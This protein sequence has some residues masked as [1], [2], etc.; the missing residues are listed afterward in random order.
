MSIR[1]TNVD[2]I[3]EAR[4]SSLPTIGR[5]KPLNARGFEGDLTFRRTPDGLK[6]YIKA[7]HQW[8]G[9]KVGESFDGLEK[10]IKEVK[11]KVDTIKQ[12][13][14]PSTYSVTGDF[15]LDA[16]GDISLDAD[17]GEI[18]IKD[19]GTTFGTFTTDSSRTSL[20]LYENAGASADDY[21]S[22]LVQT[23]GATVISTVDAAGQSG[24]IIISPDGELEL[25]A[26][27][28]EAVIVDANTTA[29]ASGTNEGLQIDYDHTGI[30]ASG[31]TVT[32]VALDIDLNSNAPTH[33]GTVVNYGI[34]IELTAATSGV[35]NQT[36]IY[37]KVLS[38]DSNTGYTSR[39]T[40]GGMDFQLLSTANTSDYCS[41]STTTNGAT[42]I[43]TVDADAANADLTVNIDGDI[44]LNSVTGV[45]IA[46]NNSTEFSVAK[47][48]YAG[49]ILGYQLIGESAVHSSYTFTTS[50][51]VPDS[52][53]NVKFVAP[54][55]GAVEITVQFGID[56]ASG[57]YNAVGLSD[58]ATYNSIGNSYEVSL[59]LTDETDRNTMQHS[60]VVTGL[61]AGT[62]YQYWLGAKSTHASGSIQWGGTST[63][64]YVDFIMKA[65]ALPAAVADYAV[66]N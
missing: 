60:W 1:R 45:F 65:V 12:F 28:N 36:G 66:Y 42:T 25:Q 35:Q 48:S 19:G 4:K 62:A 59:N 6:L 3:N 24:N 26:A 21:F 11:S 40:D 54:P 16:S 46:Q 52:A 27:D 31:Q 2:R 38:G 44:T 5:G 39:V 61:T 47:S 17:G 63:G 14:L 18:Y 7:N 29:T 37:N 8:H 43:A 23:A 34:D 9:V 13:R 55:S 10:V 15:T 51:A 53:M 57:R 58:N 30:S 32:N 56:G 20:I 41:I 50:Y 33:V 64:R 22:I 49:M